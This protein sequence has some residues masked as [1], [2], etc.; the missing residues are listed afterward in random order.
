MQS[1]MTSPKN[2]RM[3][4]AKLNRKCTECKKLL[5]NGA[6]YVGGKGPL[7]NKHALRVQVALHR[8]KIEERY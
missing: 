3:D 5:R 6:H 8:I 7:C 2:G 1:F 4:Y